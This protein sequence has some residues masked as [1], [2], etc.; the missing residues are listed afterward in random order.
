MPLPETIGTDE[1]AEI[2]RGAL[3]AGVIAGV[4]FDEICA[5]IDEALEDARANP[6]QFTNPP[7]G[8]MIEFEP[9]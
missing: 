6:E 9:D 8:G 5:T 1:I 3:Y 2:V 4:P 7:K